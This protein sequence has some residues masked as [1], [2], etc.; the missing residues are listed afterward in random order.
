MHE[1]VFIMCVYVLSEWEDLA[2]QQVP[3]LTQSPGPTAPA[4]FKEGILLFHNTVWYE[5]SQGCWRWNSR[6]HAC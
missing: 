6:S 1:F 2:K 5:G 4:G 3:I